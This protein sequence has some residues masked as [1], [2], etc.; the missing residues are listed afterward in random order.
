MATILVAEDDADYQKLLVKYLTSEGYT[1]RTAN[2][3]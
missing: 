2:G 3:W 1:V